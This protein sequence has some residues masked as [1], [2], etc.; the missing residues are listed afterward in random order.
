MFFLG[1]IVNVKIF[2]NEINFKIKDWN[3]IADNFKRRRGQ[4]VSNFIS[5][6][7]VFK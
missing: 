6:L 4:I 2:E 5:E 1:A 3:S 7:I